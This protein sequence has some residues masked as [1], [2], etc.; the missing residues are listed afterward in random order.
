[1]HRTIHA[2]VGPT[3][4][5][6]THHALEALAS[7]ASGLYAGP[8]R[9]LAVEIH[10]R[11]NAG[12][13]PC[14]LRTG[15]EVTL[16]P[17]A[18]HTACTVEMCALHVPVDV[19]VVDEI[20]LLAHP[21]RGWAW[22]RA[23][24]GLPAKTIHVC[25]SADTLPL[26][27]S[28]VA[29]CG[30]ELV[31]HEYERLTP[32]KVSTSLRGDL[33]AIRSGDCVVAFSRKE[34]FK[35]KQH[36]E[37]TG[38]QC[39]VVYGSLPPETRRAQAQLFND[40]NEAEEVLVASDAVGMGLNLNIRRI[41][42]AS[43]SKFDGTEV[44][45]LEPTEVKQIA[46]RAGRFKSRYGAGLV[47]CLQ[48]SDMAHLREA[49]DAPLAPLTEAG[50]A[51]TFEQLEL[52]DRASRH[53]LDYPD[54]LRYFEYSARL[55]KRFFVCK[56]EP[57]VQKAELISGADLPLWDRH[58]L[59]QA[60]MD[61]RDSLHAN[62]LHMWARD[63]A[64]GKE[65]RLR[66]SPPERAPVSHTEL[67]A[68]ESYFRALDG[69]L[70][71]SQRFPVAFAPHVETAI[72]Y[73]ATC[74]Q[75]IETALV[76]GLAGMGMDAVPVEALKRMAANAKAKAASMRE[77]KAM[78]SA[79]SREQSVKSARKKLKKTKAKQATRRRQRRSSSHPR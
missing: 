68:L 63:L 17:G 34:I 79:K 72:E 40:P 15:Q 11:L 28:L 64:K 24:L 59:C 22:S 45:L 52:L 41:V 8:L 2:H 74:A 25:G 7:A 75:L 39:G 50:L 1:M 67:Q 49:L 43:L 77:A 51:P 60:P 57:L 32:L 33:S 19:A 35:L 21:E 44:R 23:L 16:I 18:D 46:G 9:L 5:G 42:F 70:W 73:R 47:T 30:D 20:Q 55:D 58:T 48:Q 71:L 62:L 3:N 66:Y 27:R 36:V 10:D 78:Q 37:A 54:L 13:V 29:A 69:F 14:D 65:A 26:L 6:K 76:Q 38:L 4:S 53:G 12:G 31:E 61:A 56:L